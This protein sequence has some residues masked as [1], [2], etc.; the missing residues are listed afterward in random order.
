MT[1]NLI[2]QAEAA[3]DGVTPGN[4]QAKWPDPYY[5]RYIASD[6]VTTCAET[7]IARLSMQSEADARFIAWCRAGVPALIARIRELEG[8][9]EASDEAHGRMV[10]MWG[11]ADRA[12]MDAEA[13]LAEVEKERDEARRR[14]D[15]WKAK[16]EGYDELSAAVRAKIKAEP[17]TMSRVLL[18][19]ALIEADRR[20]ETAEAT[21]ATLTAQV[22]AMRGALTPSADT[23]ADYIG[24]FSFDYCTGF[25]ADGNEVVSRISVPWTTIKEIMAAI[26]ARAAITTENPNG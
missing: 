17:A 13:K 8:E 19:A 16:A 21:V 9:R 14:R 2:A 15:E 25:D 23:K 4:W 26:R 1:D 11:K 5:H 22:E 18:K 6:A 3:L 7:A 12:R 10:H 24:E 20:A